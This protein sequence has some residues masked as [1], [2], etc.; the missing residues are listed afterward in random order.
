MG[1]ARNASRAAKEQPS[2]IFRTR[3]KTALS[4]GEKVES[5]ALSL[6]ERVA[7]GG[8]FS[9]RRGPGEG[10]LALPGNTALSLGEKAESTALSLGERVAR[11][12]AFSSR[13]GSGEGFLAL[14][15]QLVPLELRI[16]ISSPL[17]SSLMD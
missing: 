13:R 16:G 15:S 6:G 4:L 8:A 11:G 9:S 12:G 1:A 2:S 7:C 10:F 5:T 17:D 3:G 14:P